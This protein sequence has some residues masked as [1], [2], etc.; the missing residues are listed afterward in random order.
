MQVFLM[1]LAIYFINISLCTDL[2]ELFGH[3]GQFHD[4][5]NTVQCS[6]FSILLPSY[7]TLDPRTVL[8]RLVLSSD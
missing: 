6:G 1:I 7:I 3:G 8:P 5:S 2:E 4:N